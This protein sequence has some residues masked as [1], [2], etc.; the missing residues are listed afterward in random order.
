[1]RVVLCVEGRFGH[2][3]Q[4]MCVRQLDYKGQERRATFWFPSLNH[5]ANNVLFPF[6]VSMS[7]ALIYRRYL[8]ARTFLGP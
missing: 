3:T 8:E 2:G 7:Y 6:T 1:M 4:L 5:T